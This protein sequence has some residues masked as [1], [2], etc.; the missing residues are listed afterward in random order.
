MH[1]NRT[2]RRWLLV[3]VVLLASA[4]AGTV[5]AADFGA[6]LAGAQ[7]EYWKAMEDGITQAGADLKV[8]VLV[9]SP[10][11]DDPQTT[12]DN[13]QLK[14]VR[15]LI[16]TGVQS[17]I[18]APIP[19][20]GLKT[21]IDLPVPV[22]FIDR[23]STD[24]HAASTIATDNY[25]AGRAAALTLKG[26]LPVGAKVAVLRLAPDVVSTTARES[27]FIDAAKQMGFDL[28]I[29]VYIGHGIHEPQLAAEQAIKSYGRPLDAIFTPTDF[30]TVA[31]VRAIDELA[32]GKRP[33]LVGFDYRPIY[34]QYLHTGE[35]FAFVAQDAY[36]MGYTAVQTLVQL[37]AHKAVPTV[38]SIDALVVTGANIDSA[39]IVAKLK[40]YQQ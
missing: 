8:N 1:C 22:V 19:V 13:V 30:T 39:D 35:L 32:P 29:D 31:A 5:Q 38:Q 34:R 7:S 23:P 27:G 18:I 9:R 37:R 24:F 36:G 20:T 40:Q 33:K 14:I 4:G 15:S 2:L 21:P 12:K 16:A 10:M 25:A 11:D 17:L 28:V 3:T 26:Q 6:A